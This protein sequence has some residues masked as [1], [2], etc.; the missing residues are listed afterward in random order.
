[1]SS[2]IRRCV[3]EGP[4]G[5]GSGNNRQDYRVN[6]GD[7][8]HTGTGWVRFWVDWSVMQASSST[9]LGSHPAWGNLD[10]QMNQA[11]ADG[12]NTIITVYRCPHWANGTSPGQTEPGTGKDARFKVPSDLSTTGPYAR[13]LEFIM[14]RYNGKLIGLEICNEPN[15][16]MWPLYNGS[17]RVMHCHVTN[18]FIAAKAMKDK[19]GIGNWFPIIMGPGTSDST[20]NDAAHVPY[21]TFTDDLVNQLQAANFH[22]GVFC[23]WTHHNYID[24]EYDQGSNS[25]TGRYTLRAADVR[26][27]ITGK[28]AGWPNGNAATTEVFL[29]EGGVRLKV[30]DDVYDPPA[31]YPNDHYTWLRSK[32]A[33][34]L[35]RSWDRLA[36]DGEGARIAMLTWY[37]FT[38]DPNY[39]CGLRNVETDPVSPNGERLAYWDWK[40]FP[41][42]K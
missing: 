1:M 25:S 38:S 8:L 4:N 12:L 32:Q 42:V 23:A 36:N 10:A 9:A 41:T 20:R 34:L 13:L 24:M 31:G 22:A 2:N 3:A 27:R 35:R 26:N 18:M 40:S 30:V 39:D 7:F 14:S 28:F 29:T 37:L 16:Q 19:L 11:V 17:D 6:R 21:S 15:G 33:Q 5:V